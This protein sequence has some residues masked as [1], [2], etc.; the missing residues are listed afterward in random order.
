MYLR[1]LH[2][3]QYTEMSTYPLEYLGTLLVLATTR[4]VMFVP[5]CQQTCHLNNIAHRYL[6]VTSVL[7]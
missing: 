5:H 6:V 4:I 1:E 3:R 7:K 2:G